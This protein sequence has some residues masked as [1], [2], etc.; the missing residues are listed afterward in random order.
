MLLTH[1]ELQY[2]TTG[3]YHHSPNRLVKMQGG[4][5]V[6]VGYLETDVGIARSWGTVG[7]IFNSFSASQKSFNSAILLVEFVS[8]G[9]RRANSPM[10]K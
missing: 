6:F 7:I 1:N 9:H 5:N 2:K 3:K 10:Q 4:K 8:A